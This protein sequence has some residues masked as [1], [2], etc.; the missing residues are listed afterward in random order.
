V[1]QEQLP[2]RSN[3]VAYDLELGVVV[4]EREC[5]RGNK[6]DKPEKLDCQFLIAPSVFSNICDR[7]KKV[8][9]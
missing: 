9:G 7:R 6:K 1:E 4:N 8:A 2:F 5:R 3:N